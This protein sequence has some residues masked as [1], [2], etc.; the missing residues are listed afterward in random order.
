MSK[1]I[2]LAQQLV[3]CESVTPDDAGCQN[4]IADRL[5]PL[6]FKH[7]HLK[8]GDVDNLWTVTDG[9]GP[10]FVFAGHTDVVPTG[11]LEKWT[12]PP[13]SAEIHNERLYGRGTSDMKSSIAAMIV[14]VERLLSKGSINGRIGFLI[15]SDEEGPAVN[16][17][18]KV[19]EY[20]ESNNIKIDWCVVGEPTSTD[21]LG[22]V[23]K[24]GRRGSLNGDLTIKGKQGHVAYPHLGDNPVHR[25]SSSLTA[26]TSEVWDSGNEFFPATTFQ[27]S[28]IHA[29]TGVTNVIPGEL[30]VK[31][32]F[33]FSTELTADDLKR[34]V[35]DILD[36]HKL[37]YEINWNL[38]G[39]PFITGR[40]EL[41]NATVDAIKKV[42]STNAEL[43]TSGGTSDGRFIA[44]TG[45]QVLELGPCNATIHQIDEHVT[46]A[47]LDT[48]TDVYEELLRNLLQNNSVTV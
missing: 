46:V 34:R 33:R 26:L 31:F 17:T 37:D 29:G 21:K 47:E 11:P 19:I 45:A 2:E 13:F 40:G 30:S 38:S 44:P 5:T 12:H 4:I 32:N 15:T 16:G 10:L 6:G 36:T 28:N 42:T 14:A 48:L 20:L 35:T 25:F 1:T 39:N 41:V 8:H 18:V 43:S 23:I 24:N 7:T 3:R 27:I 22:D 9:T